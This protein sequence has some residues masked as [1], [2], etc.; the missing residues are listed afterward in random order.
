VMQRFYVGTDVDVAAVRA[1]VAAARHAQVAAAA[2][3]AQMAAAARNAQTAVGAPPA[4]AAGGISAGS[5]DDALDDGMGAEL[6]AIGAD[7]LQAPE[8]Q[9]LQ[10]VMGT[11]YWMFRQH[12]ARN[13]VRARPSITHLHTLK[14]RDPHW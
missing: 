10:D 12:Y 1:L 7:T 4:A 3:N 11:A 5:D 8:T 14:A 9:G 6:L 2:R 13:Q